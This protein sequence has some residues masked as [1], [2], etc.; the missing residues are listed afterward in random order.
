VCVDNLKPNPNRE[1]SITEIYTNI[2][3]LLNTSYVNANVSNVESIFMWK[4]IVRRG[5]VKDAF[6]EADILESRNMY[7]IGVKIQ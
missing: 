5:L 2:N 1:H 4:N 7:L 6:T 3:L